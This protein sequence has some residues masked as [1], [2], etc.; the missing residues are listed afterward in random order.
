MLI[1]T[2]QK[3]QQHQEDLLRLASFRPFDDTFMR[4]MFK[5]NLP[6]AE[7]ILRI[8]LNKEDLI[9]TSM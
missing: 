9:L 1:D 8:I 6:L 7:M 5:E 3:S 4:A 2:Q